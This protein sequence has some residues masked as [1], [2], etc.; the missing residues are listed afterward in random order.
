MD[1]DHRR[2]QPQ[3]GGKPVAGVV[4]HEVPPAV[5]I[6]PPIDMPSIPRSAVAPELAIVMTTCNPLRLDSWLAY[7]AA[8][9][10]PRAIFIRVDRTPSLATLFAQPSWINLVHA[11]F[12][13][14]M[15]QA[16]QGQ[17]GVRQ[18]STQL[19]AH[20]NASV[21][22]AREM[23][24]THL[25]HIDD[26]ELLFAAAGLDELHAALAAAPSEASDIHVHNVEAL[27]P[28]PHCLDPF[29]A[30]RA[31]RYQP[32]GYDAYLNGKSFGRLGDPDLHSRGPHHFR[33]KDGEYRTWQLPAHVAVVLH[34]ES[35]TFDRWADKYV[36]LSSRISLDESRTIL[37]S[38]YLQRSVR[39]AHTLLKWTAKAEAEEPG[40]QQ[41]LDQA[42]R[43]SLQ[44]WCKHK[45]EPRG[46]PTRAE[47]RQGDIVRG[48]DGVLVTLV[49]PFPAVGLAA[50]AS[51]DA[52]R[53]A[54]DLPLLCR[55]R[56]V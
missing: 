35:C 44:L 29:R 56:R 20:V 18:N 28:S 12:D 23:G 55:G 40:A 31:F 36:G 5:I 43:G 50:D 46:L 41:K 47:Q 30:A 1:P 21:L 49:D 22:A 15:Q 37:P 14:T 6:K 9:L 4:T 17:R 11:T 19:T 45:L 38:P 48:A 3:D 32:G 39:A 8:A 13:D 53:V 24:C 54:R 33:S 16:G 7:H 10:R 42:W 51:V 25:L 34:F 26:D 52:E 2:L 27:M